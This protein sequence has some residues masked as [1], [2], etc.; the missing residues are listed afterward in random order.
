M[1]PSRARIQFLL[2][3][4]VLISPNEAVSILLLL[5]ES[6]LLLTI[7]SCPPQRLSTVPR[8]ERVG[9]EA[10]VHEGKMSLIIGIHQIMVV[11]VNLNW[12][13]LPLVDNVLVGEGADVEPVLKPNS[14]SGPLPE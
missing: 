10:R 6:D 12:C 4:R 9:G 14:M 7:V 2:P 5:A 1:T 8:R 11:L 3:R 13:Q